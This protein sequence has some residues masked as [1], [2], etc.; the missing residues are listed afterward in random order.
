[1]GP[2]T[3]TTPDRYFSE[4][5]LAALYDSFCVGRDDFDFYFDY[6]VRA[7][8]ALDAG[9]GTGALLREVRVR[10]HMGRLVGLDPAIGMLAVARQRA[11]IEWIDGTLESVAFDAEFDL[12]VMCGHAFQVLLTD[13]EIERT[14]AAV[15]KAPRPGCRFAFETRNPDARAW[16]CWHDVHRGTVHNGDGNDVEMHTTLAGPMRDELITFTHTFNCADW[17]APETSTS[18][19]RFIRAERLDRLLTNAGFT[20]EER[21]GDWNRET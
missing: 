19:L 10:G 18:T 17:D 2:I 9:C 13:A 20:I 14:L 12:A 5:R 4:P 6:V 8:T 7:D 16:E 11:D 1:M 15:F 21:F 3:M